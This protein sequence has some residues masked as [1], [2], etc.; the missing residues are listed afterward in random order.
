MFMPC[1]I[2]QTPKLQK[3]I[4]HFAEYNVTVIELEMFNKS[5][6][7]YSYFYTFRIQTQT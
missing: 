1:M 3:F 4:R 2:K 5:T 7:N 6:Y